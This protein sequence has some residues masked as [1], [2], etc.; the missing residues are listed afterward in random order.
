MHTDD[1]ELAVRGRII[2]RRAPTRVVFDRSAK[3][4][5]DSKL[6][7]T[8]GSVPTVVV[9]RPGARTI[10]ALRA[11][12]VTV[13]ECTDTLPALEKLRSSGVQH[14]FVEGGAGLAQDLLG[15]GLVDR[16]IIF[17]TQVPLGEGGAKPFERIE[18]LN[19]RRI[20]ERS[21]FG[22]DDGKDD[23]TVYELKSK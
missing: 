3:I 22:K 10:P 15:A 12:G 11:A 20:V 18:D 1:P 6:V 7:R 8:A 9:T 14:L 13:I 16:L 17:Q 23:M 4:P 21:R 2:P 5:L 19:V